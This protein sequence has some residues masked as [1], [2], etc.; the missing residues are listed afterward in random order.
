MALNFLH[1]HSNCLPSILLCQLLGD[2]HLQ[3]SLYGCSL[4]D[5]CDAFAM[6]CG[7]QH[8]LCHG[9]GCTSVT[10]YAYTPPGNMIMLLMHLLGDLEASPANVVQA[11]PH[12][13]I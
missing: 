12:S 5:I 6:N 8:M 1:L 9:K 4:P 10:W 13:T 3:H 7:S 2:K 11:E